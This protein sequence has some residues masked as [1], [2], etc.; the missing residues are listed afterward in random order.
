LSEFGSIPGVC[1]V[2]FFAAPGS[3]ADSPR[4]LIEIA[5]G[6][7]REAEFDAVRAR[8]SP[9]L[10]SDLKDYFLVNTDAGAPEY[11]RAV[12][13]RLGHPVMLVRSLLP[14]TFLDCNRLVEAS[15]TGM[16]SAFPDYIRDEA[17]RRTLLSLY[18]PYQDL[19]RRAY[20]RV[21]GGGGLGLMLHSYAPR[22][23]EIDSIDEGIGAALRRAYE[24]GTYERW[25]IRPDADLITETPSGERLAPESLV[26]GLRRQFSAAGIQATQNVSYKLHPATTAHG[27]AAR[28]P[29]RTLCLEVNRALLCNPFIP[30]EEL[31][32][33]GQRVAPVAEA[34][35]GACRE[36]LR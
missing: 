30:F 13:Q 28:W 26:E 20:D 15:G 4:V 21:C 35:A 11:A 10:P 27:H 25:A 18:E 2:E 8:L 9:G 31:R 5:H 33:D 1:E 16:T 19:V 14:R 23:V 34:I 22:S 3:A 29:G 12:A 17:D 6:A 7:T 36:F 24:P 32:V